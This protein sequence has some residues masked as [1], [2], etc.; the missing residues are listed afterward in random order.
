MPVVACLEE[1]VPDLS[2][3]DLNSL[4]FWRHHTETGFDYWHTRKKNSPRAIGLIVSHR[5]EVGRVPYATL[6]ERILD[7]PFV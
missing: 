4:T 5:Y 7:M 3:A 1:R 2:F 6:L